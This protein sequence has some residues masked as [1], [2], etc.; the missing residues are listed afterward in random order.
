MLSPYSIRLLG[1]LIFLPFSQPGKQGQKA[2]TYQASGRNI[3]DFDTSF[4]E[5]L[6]ASASD[7]GRIAVA[8]LPSAESLVEPSASL[9]PT[10][11]AA[12]NAPAQKAVE[13][14]KFH[15]TSSGLLLSNQGS[16]V[17]VW[18]YSS[19]GEAQAIYTFQGPA[20]GHWSV[21]WSQ[22]GRLIQTTGKDNTFNLWDVR[23][24]TEKPIAVSDK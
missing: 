10:S 22:D 11:T 21:S 12:F 23:Q 13:V 16:D 17:Q 3:T 8:S 9:S 24:S 20:K 6:V 2:A 14:V 15:P 18:D 5:P 1:T 19:G 4:L 7:D